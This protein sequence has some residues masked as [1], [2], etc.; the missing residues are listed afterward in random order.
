[1]TAN[2]ALAPAVAK[3]ERRRLYPFGLVCCA[4]YAAYG[5]RLSSFLVRRQAEESY[6][7]RFEVLQLKPG[8][9]ELQASKIKKILKAF[10]H[11]EVNSQSPT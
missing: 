4:L 1:M 9:S 7:P 8:C 11:N 5:L 2:A 3:L 10:S 6:A